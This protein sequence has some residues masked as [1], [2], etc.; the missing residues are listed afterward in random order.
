MSGKW[1][2]QTAEME[3]SIQ[4]GIQAEDE[5]TIGRWVT[6]GIQKTYRW[7]ARWYLLITKGT[8]KKTVGNK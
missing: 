6:S 4:S 1:F 8:G 2:W 3:S 5:Q 7:A